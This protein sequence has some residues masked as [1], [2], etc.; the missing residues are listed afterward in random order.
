[1]P[2]ELR[3][4]HRAATITG[5]SARRAPLVLA[6]L[7]AAGVVVATIAYVRTID[8][9][10]ESREASPARV[11]GSRS[12]VA[13]G[14]GAE[15]ASADGPA[16]AELAHRAA[17]APSAEDDVAPSGVGLAELAG[18]VLD[19]SGAP[20]V[21]AVVEL[22]RDAPP[23][24]AG[25]RVFVPTWDPL[26]PDAFDGPVP[27]GRGNVLRR[28]ETTGDDGRFLFV[29]VTPARWRIA[30]RTA[31]SELAA[32][33]L[34]DVAPGA[35]REDL[36]LRLA[37]APRVLVLVLGADGAPVHGARVVAGPADERAASLLARE[38]RRF[39][40]EP[41]RAG[42]SAYERLVT[43]PPQSD[44]LTD[45]RGRASLALFRC[46]RWRVAARSAGSPF[47]DPHAVLE[48]DLARLVAGREFTARAET[49]GAWPPPALVTL[50][51]APGR[52]IVGRVANA[53]GEPVAAVVRATEELD[54]ER[55]ERVAFQRVLAEARC[56]VDG[57][58]VLDDLP[59][60]PCVVLAR[61]G[62]E[63]GEA[64]ARVEFVAGITRRD[65]SLPARPTLAGRVLGAD[66]TPRAGANVELAVVD[67]GS[68]ARA[69]V[70]SEGGR[71]WASAEP[72]TRV[73][74]RGGVRLRVWRAGLA[75]DE[76]G[77]FRV[78]HAPLGRVQLV[79]SAS[80]ALASTP[81]ALDVHGDE[82]A[83]DVVLRLRDGAG[84]E[85]RAFGR[86]GVALAGE[87]VHFHP[88]DDA[89]R[90]ESALT[91]AVGAFRLH[92]LEPGR[93]TFTLELEGDGENAPRVLE[94]TVELRDGAVA[95]VR[96]EP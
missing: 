17:V 25:E 18:I 71:G 11:D 26:G 54:V 94:R 75:T 29:N 8:L 32:Q 78:E 73:V 19:S 38:G 28:N 33:D 39:G 49:S 9:D 81:V 74:E 16:R 2:F 87:I 56:G 88:V 89:E 42:T 53:R 63:Y 68:E 79:A 62:D 15:R 20:V 45:E 4:V 14:S 5:M 82:D 24:H 3:P 84:V 23:P 60:R 1:M 95:S 36:V 22:E 58:F 80:D 61:A 6:S 40:V 50:E 86:G 47:A 55:G 92:R 35:R 70:W 37:P 85:G 76:A 12:T 43:T 57:V 27:A 64:R 52:A 83:L 65:L 31:E 41:R 30:T 21:G 91:D 77:R 46:D 69:L 96:L 67:P 44:A 93:W 34:G 66:G 59:A 48:P 10:G 51:L 90:V 7:V 72:D 13:N